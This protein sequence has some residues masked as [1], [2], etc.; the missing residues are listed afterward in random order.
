MWS[1]VTIEK[2]IIVEGRAERTII[3]EGEAEETIVAEGEAGRT[4]VIATRGN[5]PKQVYKAI[6]KQSR[7]PSGPLHLVVRLKTDVVM[8]VSLVER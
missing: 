4:T 7:R 3:V 2:T 6:N 8:D 5:R 1:N